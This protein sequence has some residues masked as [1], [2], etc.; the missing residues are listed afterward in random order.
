ML[1]VKY[2]LQ[3]DLC[4]SGAQYPIMMKFVMTTYHHLVLSEYSVSEI[5]VQTLRR[6]CFDISNNRSSFAIRTTFTDNQYDRPFLLFTNLPKEPH[7]IGY[8]LVFQLP[9]RSSLSLPKTPTLL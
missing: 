6:H 2:I 1:V 8:N 9:F 3:K 4:E 5:V 7:L